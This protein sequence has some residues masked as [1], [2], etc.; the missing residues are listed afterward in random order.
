MKRHYLLSKGRHL[1]SNVSSSPFAKRAMD[2]WEGIVE[3]TEGEHLHEGLMKW[4]NGVRRRGMGCYQI[5]GRH[6]SREDCIVA[7]C[8]FHTAPNALYIV[9]PAQTNKQGHTQGDK[10]VNKEKHID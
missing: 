9:R 6:F 2:E 4:K 8:Q 1:C 10:Q 5:P 7:L 3:W